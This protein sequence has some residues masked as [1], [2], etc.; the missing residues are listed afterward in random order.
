[1]TVERV[2]CRN[3]HFTRLF[4]CAACLGTMSI[5]QME[6]LRVGTHKGARSTGE[7]KGEVPLKPRRACSGPGQLRRAL[8]ASPA[9]SQRAGVL[10]CGSQNERGAIPPLYLFFPSCSTSLAGSAKQVLHNLAPLEI[11]VAKRPWGK[12]E[13]NFE[14][15]GR[16]PPHIPG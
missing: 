16:I 1:M 4:S 5:F 8:G 14:F 15:S 12:K 9:P 13:R 3:S 2:S 10:Q 11:S 7:M 6:R